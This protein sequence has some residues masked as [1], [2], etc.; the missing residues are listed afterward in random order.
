MI[1]NETQLLVEN[2]DMIL[3][4]HKMQGGKSSFRNEGKNQA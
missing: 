2:K 4:T 1:R 3:H